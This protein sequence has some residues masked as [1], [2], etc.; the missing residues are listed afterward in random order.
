[1]TSKKKRPPVRRCKVCCTNFKVG[2]TFHKDCDESL[3]SP[4]KRARTVAAKVH[5]KEKKAQEE[6]RI[7][8]HRGKETYKKQERP[9]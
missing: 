9:T 6:N 8:V 1:M 2:E 3:G 7:G 4:G 5:A